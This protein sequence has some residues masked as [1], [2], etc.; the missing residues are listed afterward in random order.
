MPNWSRSGSTVMKMPCSRSASAPHARATARPGQ[1]LQDLLQESGRQDA[2]Q[3]QHGPL[4]GQLPL[5]PGRPLACVPPLRQRCG[6]PH[7]RRAHA[8]VACALKFQAPGGLQTAKCVTLGGDSAPCWGFP[9]VGCH[10][11]FVECVHLRHWP[12][13]WAGGQAPCWRHSPRG[14]AAHACT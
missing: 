12:C 9:M 5:R 11:V 6:R 14:G 1:R 3:L 8:V 10:S 7:G 13:Q 4:G 2:H